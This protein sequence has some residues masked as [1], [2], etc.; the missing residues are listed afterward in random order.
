MI[1]TQEAVDEMYAARAA[2]TSTSNANRFMGMSS[3]IVDTWY[4]QNGDDLQKQMLWNLR[5]ELEDANLGGD[6]DPQLLLSSP[7]GR[8]QFK[9]NGTPENPNRLFSPG[10]AVF[11]MPHL[12]FNPCMR[13]CAQAALFSAGVPTTEMSLCAPFINLSFYHNTPPLENVSSFLGGAHAKTRGNMISFL[14]T[15]KVSMGTADIHMANASLSDGSYS[16]GRSQNSLDHGSFESSGEGEL[17]SGIAQDDTFLEVATQS[18][19]GMELFTSP[20]TLVN[21]DINKEREASQ[22]VLDPTQPFMSLESISVKEYASGF[23]LIGFKKA[24]VNIT[25]HDRS[26]LGEVS[27]FIAPASFG[28]VSALLEFGWSHPN[29]D[30]L[31]GSPYGKFLNTLRNTSKYRLIK[32]NYNM[33]ASGQIKITLEMGTMGGEDSKVTNAFTGDFVHINEINSLLRDVTTEILRLTTNGPISE[34]IRD[35]QRLSSRDAG[36]QQMIE[37]R[38]YDDLRH[39]LYEITS[40]SSL[41]ESRIQ[42]MLTRTLS[43]LED[44]QPE[45]GTAAVHTTSPQELCSDVI[46]NL[47]PTSTQTDDPWITDLFPLAMSAAEADD[48]YTTIKEEL[49][50]AT[51]ST[52]TGDADLINMALE[53]LQEVELKESFEEAVEEA[54]EERD[55][56]ELKE[57]L[58]L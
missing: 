11:D 32:G 48:Q 38:V 19:T 47:S 35:V 39:M 3:Y 30:L 24:T 17:G 12:M 13:H 7:L 57:S 9:I 15:G 20:Q 44:V 56:D 46:R 21:M 31:S 29:G 10:L 51:M 33:D 42:E 6:S 49:S 28:Q 50:F 4:D 1:V 27:Q 36:S 58:K 5:V 16:A 43:L 54:I 2:S 52:H 37:R 22:Y 25:L 34:E 26:R 40:Q 18:R 14:G 41:S 23:G 53:D 45:D 55:A 8:S